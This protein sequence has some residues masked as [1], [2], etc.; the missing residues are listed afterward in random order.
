[1]SVAGNRTNR[2][3]VNFLEFPTDIGFEIVPYRLRYKLSLRNLAEMFLL[4]GFQ[5]TYETVRDWEARFAPAVLPK[6]LTAKKRRAGYW[7]VDNFRPLQ[8]YNVSPS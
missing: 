1:M 5:F 8:R 2:Y 4:R 6:M 7:S 3:S